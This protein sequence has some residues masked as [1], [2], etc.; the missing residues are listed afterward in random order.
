MRTIPRAY[1]HRR[2]EHEKLRERRKLS[3]VKERME[4]GQKREQLLYAFN[5]PVPTYQRPLIKVV[6]NEERIRN[7]LVN[8]DTLRSKREAQSDLL[9]KRYRQRFDEIKRR[10]PLLPELSTLHE[11][12]ATRNAASEVLRRQ[13]TLESQSREQILLRATHRLFPH[14]LFEG[15]PVHHSPQ[16]PVQ[17]QKQPSVVLKELEEVTKRDDMARFLLEQETQKAGNLTLL[18]RLSKEVDFKELQQRVQN[19]SPSRD[20]SLDRERSLTRQQ[21]ALKIRRDTGTRFYQQ[22]QSFHA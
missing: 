6:E 8:L 15:E 1:D 16:P 3:V 18:T 17:R 21:S 11:K 7:A 5:Q 2:V 12:F 22:S 20:S 19:L 10:E 9:S 13:R 14:L 4:T